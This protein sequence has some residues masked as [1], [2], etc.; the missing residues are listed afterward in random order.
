[1]ILIIEIME[2]TDCG[3]FERKKSK[4]EKQL[5]MAIDFYW[6]FFC[7]QVLILDQIKIFLTYFTLKFW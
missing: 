7:I 5:Y 3:N 2:M 6:L 4:P 1:M